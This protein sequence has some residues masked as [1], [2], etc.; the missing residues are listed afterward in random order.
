MK[1]P[2]KALLWIRGSVILAVC[3]LALGALGSGSSAGAD[4]L[5][6]N[7]ND[8]GPGSLRQAILDAGSGQ[9]ITFSVYGTITL[10]TGVL[11]INKNLNIEGP[12]PQHL[13]ISGNHT[14]RV[15][16]IFPDGSG[17]PGKVTLTGMTISDGLAD[18]DSP[19]YPIGLDTR[20]AGG[21]ILNLYFLIL[22][23]V[24]VSGNRAI[25]DA[26][27]APLGF[28]GAGFGGAVAN[29][30]MLTVDNSA[31]IGNLARG[32][33]GINTIDS[34]P[35][36]S[37][38]FA[39]GG[40]ILNG[41][42]LTIIH[43]RFTRNQAIGGNDS[44]SAFF[45]GHAPGGAIFSA[46]SEAILHAS[47]SEFRHNQAIGGNGNVS[48]APADL[49]ANKGTGGAINVAGGKA[50]IDRCTFMHNW[51]IGGAGDSGAA[52]GGI[53]GAGAIMVTNAGGYGTEATVSNSK[54]KHNIAL[55]GPGNA[56]GEGGD[57]Q[58]GGLI[59]AAGGI[60]TV[61][62]TTVAR[63]HAQGG[64]GG[65][66][67]DGGEGLGGGLYSQLNTVLALEGAIVTKNL[68]LG[69]EAGSGGNE[70]E[71]I[72]GGVYY[73]GTYS[74]D[75]ATVIKKNQATTSHDNLWPY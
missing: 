75:K 1:H 29:A 5:V 65:E 42:Q 70:G 10:T 22:S 63:N 62:D 58:G 35:P 27:T 74:A 51:S 24:V 72:G 18:A 14:S 32:A 39:G 2:K 20:S 7:L 12:G 46:A 6:T 3:A 49:G 23:D 52:D 25:G 16:V 61:I 64:P 28:P 66:G 67:G 30:G 15:F 47:D 9:T 44:S 45:P 8:S 48:L 13:R 43:S 55:G 41:G 71:G 60:L 59:C 73:L 19:F 34:V 57:G 36:A 37:A 68:S 17:A 50:T 69:G 56:G 33:D 26:L 11:K 31:F 4:I 53:G 38:G 40:G 21:A 54:I